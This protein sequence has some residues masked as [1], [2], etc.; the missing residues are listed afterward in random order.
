[1]IIAISGYIG[2]GKDTVGQ[3]IKEITRT[4]EYKT[5]DGELLPIKDSDW[6][7]KKFAYKLKTVASILTGIPQ[8][9]FEDQE[10][11]KSDLSQ[12]WNVLHT[13]LTTT[14]RDNWTPELQKQLEKEN[15][16][17]N[18]R[19]MTVREFLQKLGTESMRDGLH[20]NV[21]VNAL[22]ADY[23]GVEN[24]GYP[25]YGTTEDGGRIPVDYTRFIEYPK[26][27]VTDCRFPNEAE[28]VKDRDGFVVRINRDL[29]E[30]PYQ[31]LE[32]RHPS[33]T[34]LD[35]WN[36]DYVIQNDSTVEVLRDKVADMLK[37]F[38]IKTVI[39]S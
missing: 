35:D 36:F 2:S 15:W 25:I 17:K 11:K 10:F 9:K 32:Q 14:H 5:I 33:E 16:E 39:T 38:G 34:S 13:T 7:I 28:A 3:I 18:N 37:H 27:I 4:R 22:F 31:T 8:H 26:W 21:W 29:P 6:K 23:K 19:P 30:V 20:T 24:G 1:M 12:E